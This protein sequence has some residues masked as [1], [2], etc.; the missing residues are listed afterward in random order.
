MN[1]KL[2]LISSFIVFFVNFNLF[3]ENT[4]KTNEES[5]LKKK[6]KCSKLERDECKKSETVQ[7]V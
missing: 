7:M 1:N 4:N 5:N 3:T 6:I 2:I